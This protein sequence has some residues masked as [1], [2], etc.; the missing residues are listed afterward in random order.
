MLSQYPGGHGTSA[1][2][3]G[4]SGSP[5]PPHV[6]LP[7]ISLSCSKSSSFKSSSGEK[8]KSNTCPFHVPRKGKSSVQL[9]IGGV[10]PA[11]PPEPPVPADPAEPPAASEPPTAA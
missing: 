8:K 10:A 11:S 4:G 2:S 5:S 1:L 3:T 7:A 9:V 6:S